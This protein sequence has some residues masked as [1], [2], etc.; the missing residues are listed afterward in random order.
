MTVSLALPKHC[1]RR[2]VF[3][4][5]IALQAQT[6]RA[7]SPELKILAAYTGTVRVRY[8]FV[9]GSFFSVFRTGQCL[10]GFGIH[11][12]DFAVFGRSDPH[13]HRHGVQDALHVP[14]AFPYHLVAHL[15]HQESTQYIGKGF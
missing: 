11:I 3:L 4:F 2:Q 1:N 14:V 15:V 6:N 12:Q 7:I 9:T 8:D 5:G 10:P 13:F